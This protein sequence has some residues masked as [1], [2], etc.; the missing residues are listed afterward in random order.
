MEKKCCDHGIAIENYYRKTER[1]M[2]AIELVIIHLDSDIESSGE[3]ESESESE[4][5]EEESDSETEN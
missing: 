1:I 5:G 2:Q 3:E 4:S